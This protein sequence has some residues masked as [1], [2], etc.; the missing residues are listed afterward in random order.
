LVADL[1]VDE[2]EQLSGSYCVKGGRY[3]NL[4]A[5]TCSANTERRNCPSPAGVNP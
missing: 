2:R 4:D 1:D 5:S 3:S